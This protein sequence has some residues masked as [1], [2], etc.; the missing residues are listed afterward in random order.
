MSKA[1]QSVFTGVTLQTDIALHFLLRELSKPAFKEVIVEGSDWEDFTMVYDDHVE[2][3]EVKWHQQPVG[4]PMVKAI[5][6]KEISKSLM[7]KDV[8]VIV[9][10]SFSKAFRNLHKSITR[11]LP[12][13]IQFDKKNPLDFES[14]KK[15]L[16]LGWNEG[17]IG[18][19]FR[20]KLVELG[21]E[22]RVKNSLL[23]HFALHDDFYFNE[24]DK[25][26]AVAVS[27]RGL[28]SA[29]TSGKRI[30]KAQF[31]ASMDRFKN[32]IAQRSESFTPN[33]SI[34]QRL[35]KL[36]KFL[37]SERM[38]K[39]LDSNQYISALSSDHRLIFTVADELS[40]NDFSLS[41]IEFFI[42]KVLIK[43][44]YVWW[45]FRILRQR[46]KSNN[47][48]PGY[49]AAFIS[50]H[51]S[52]FVE[53][54]NQRDT[55]ELLVEEAR[56][57]KRGIH[58]TSI[59]NFV[60][61]NYARSF[62]LS[63]G[64][65]F[66]KRQINTEEAHRVGDLIG[67]YWKN[68]KNRAALVHFI[69]RNFDLTGNDLENVYETSP[70]IFH[71]LKDWVAE[72]VKTRL[73]AL[74]E[75][76]A[77][78]YTARYKVAYDGTELIGSS[79]SQ[80]GS[81]I[82]LHDIGLVSLLFEPLFKDLYTKNHRE[83]WQYLKQRLFKRPIKISKKRPTFLYRA[84][85]SLLI[86]RSFDESLI[87]KEQ[88]E[89]HTMLKELIAIRRGLP[90]FSEAVFS[91]QWPIKNKN[92]RAIVE[93]ARV[94]AAY[95]EGRKAPEGLPSNYFTVS[96]LLALAALNVD[97]AKAFLRSLVA[98]PAFSLYD[99]DYFKL[100]EQ[101]GHMG[102]AAKDPDFVLT[103]FE[104]LDISAYL[105]HGGRF[106]FDKTSF[107]SQLVEQDFASGTDRG[108]KIFSS[109]IER[110]KTDEAALTFASSLLNRI[111]AIDPVK[112]Y[113]LLS[114]FLSD[115]N[116]Y[117][118]AFSKG[119]EFRSELVWLGEDLAKRGLEKEALHIVDLSWDDPDPDTNDR[120]LEYNLHVRVKTGKDVST[121]SSVRGKTAWLLQTLSL[122][123]QPQS[124]KTALDITERLLDLGGTL[125]A[126]LGYSEPDLYVRK[127]ATV[128][129]AILCHPGRRAFLNE[130][131]RIKQIAFQLLDKIDD[132][133]R[134]GGKP[135]DL[136]KASVR[137][138]HHLRDLD[139]DQ[140]NRVLSHFEAWNQP[141]AA[142]LFIYFAEYR[143][144]QYLE[145]PFDP[146]VSQKRLITLCTNDNQ[147]RRQIAWQLYKL[148]KE[149]S[150]T[151]PDLSMV[152]R[153]A[154][155]LAQ[156]FNESVFGY[157]YM[158]IEHT[159]DKS[160]ECL[161]LLK[162]MMTVEGNYLRS[163]EFG[164]IA[165]PPIEIGQW[166]AHNDPNSF[167]ELLIQFAGY[168]GDKWF[169]YNVPDWVRLFEELDSTLLVD[170]DS[171]HKLRNMLVEL[172][173]M[174][175]VKTGD[176]E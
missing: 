176:G 19:L 25:D 172:G 110:G 14:V 138:F 161:P 96:V 106:M 46:F 166:L 123:K 126:Q 125:A 129:F 156:V 10:R 154:L 147:I 31:A 169:A 101:I 142:P 51:F 135:S 155:P 55:L 109:L 157:L 149:G 118:K 145:I 139:T 30:T 134:K 76:V 2:D 119:V 117:R 167:V 73:E 20:T 82:T 141:D 131:E 104:L 17:E 90:S 163:Q 148:A 40:K 58:R 132:E 28:M 36:S 173:L 71:L 140:A 83:G 97:E 108:T 87:T 77:R 175:R 67:A 115:K 75:A 68:P 69:F 8:L 54:G 160:K 21:T 94:D 12:L 62:D 63:D 98:I 168:I 56:R 1:G 159:I 11:H 114:G 37:N 24:I 78:Q 93:L 9:A 48:P 120:D 121:I 86:N 50:K 42:K 6:A 103:L 130:N 65:T 174:K 136:A 16:R 105:K 84:V 124:A 133:Y 7:E 72:D 158:L 170:Q 165:G 5:I 164:R 79:F 32:N 15:L 91:R 100:F 162:T 107:V 128:P 61:E 44:S 27:F 52:Y 3:F 4:A 18:F 59:L 85:L 57:D 33:L 45:A 99:K 113:T 88:Q 152:F 38:F 43:K 81:H 34:G 23:E 64:W 102:L 53:T 41:T 26:L 89:A 35:E 95:Y 171:Y 49:M 137:V 74:V 13:A 127:M 153:Y 144:K 151:E 39:K 70:M 122:S 116:K 60:E 143:S 22:E 47:I 112:T 150:I 111:R 80:I 29:G 146:T 66:S 92:G